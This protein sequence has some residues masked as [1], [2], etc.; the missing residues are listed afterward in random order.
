MNYWMSSVWHRRGSNWRLKTLIKNNFAVRRW[1]GQGMLAS[2]WSLGCDTGLWLVNDRGWGEP[3]PNWGTASWFTELR[4]SLMQS[5]LYSKQYFKNT[6]IDCI[7]VSFLIM[8]NIYFTRLKAPSGCFSSWLS[9]IPHTQREQLNHLHHFHLI[10]THKP[11]QLHSQIKYRLAAHAQL[12]HFTFWR[13]YPHKYN[14]EITTWIHIDRLVELCLLS[15]KAGLP[16][17]RHN[18]ASWVQ[19]YWARQMRSFKLQQ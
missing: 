10:W 18:E 17:L 2:D 1:P 9:L 5:V 13:N 4:R 7:I 8:S 3:L 6:I 12:G 15:W 19:A 14:I 11:T 16:G